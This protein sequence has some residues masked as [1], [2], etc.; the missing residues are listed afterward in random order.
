MS[1]LERLRDAV[2]CHRAGRFAAAAAGYRAALADHPGDAGLFKA[3]GTA[4]QESGAFQEAAEA[5]E[6]ALA[7]APGDAAALSLRAGALLGLG[8]STEAVAELRLALALAPDSVGARRGLARALLAAGDE[9]ALDAYETLLRLAPQEAAS[10]C[11]YGV[12][13]ARAS[14]RTDAR[15]AFAE[16]LTRDP[17]DA[18][19]AGQQLA[20]LDG[21]TLAPDYVA[22]HFD[23]FA[24]DFE[25]KLV[26]V[27]KYDGP[28]LL[29]ELV[30]P[31]AP[32]GGARRM[33]DLGC[34]TGLCGLAFAE[35]AAEIDGVDLSPRMIDE[36]RRRGV[37]RR[38][39]CGDAL[40]ALAGA[41]AAYE[42]AVAGDVLIYVGDPD[43]W[44][45][46]LRGA[47]AP[48]GLFAFTIETGAA[49]G[50]ALADTLRYRHE[51][52][53]IEARLAAH[54]FAPAAA[55]DAP[56]RQEAG[57]PVAGRVIAARLRA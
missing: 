36:A 16:S 19:G 13:L 29:R 18:A 7:A 23:G 6:Q 21:G 26:D 56:L 20:R 3:L 27:L 46:A 10:W 11:E 24:G 12:A 54:G 39:A 17:A 33:I 9:A 37:Y 15:R 32:P 31:L 57:R 52:G 42:L 47:L 38:L 41:P 30:A 40:D 48:G 25:R 50:F 35:L 4:L 2:A 22:R 55:R 45:A 8:R 14:R 5:F 49:P 43:P 44:L 34:G 51:P 53:F 28:R 1:A